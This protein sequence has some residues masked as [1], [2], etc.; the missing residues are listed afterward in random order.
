MKVA[1]APPIAPPNVANSVAVVSLIG[2]VRGDALNTSAAAKPMDKDNAITNAHAPGQ[3]MSRHHVVVFGVFGFRSWDT[4]NP[5]S[6][7]QR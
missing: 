6:A 4:D 2:G 1:T 3:S 7:G 5:V